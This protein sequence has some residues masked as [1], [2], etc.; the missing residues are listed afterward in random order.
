MTD[1]QW[2]FCGKVNFNTS[3]KFEKSKIEII[4]NFFCKRY[5]AKYGIL[6]PSSRSSITLYMRFLKFNRKHLVSI[7]KWSSHCLFTCIGAFSNISIADPKADLIIVNHKWGNE[8]QINKKINKKKKIIE[9]SVDTLPGKNFKLFPNKG[10]IE[11]V[12]L[13]KIIGTVAGGIILTNSKKFFKY[14]KLYQ[15]RNVKLGVSQSKKKIMLTKKKLDNFDN[16]YFNE[17]WNTFVDKNLVINIL[18]N[19]DNFDENIKVIIKRIKFLQNIFNIK[20]DKKRLGPV[21]VLPYKEKIKNKNLIK[22]F[23]F[24]KKVFNEKYSKCFILPLHF[25][26]S[27]KK[28]LELIKIYKKL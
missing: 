15:K 6:M 17:A 21:I 25:K 12:S 3:D 16:W 28:F 14:A 22:Y 13:P 19:I 8:Y 18:D 11:I 10:E 23:N 26:V 20:I 2:P 5:G 27:D 24:K 7:S 4:E 1:I 9:D